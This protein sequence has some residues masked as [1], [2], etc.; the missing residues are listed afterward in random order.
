MKIVVLDGYC[1]N[2]GD[3]S[4]DDWKAL[5]DFELF[6]RTP[7]DKT[8]E[9]AR[10]AEIAITNKTVFDR[11]TIEAL[12]NLKYIG[13]LATGYNVID[14]EAAAE[15]GVPV[16]NVPAYS[17][18]SVAEHTIGL[19]L[20]LCRCAGLHSRLVREGEW[21]SSEDFS[22]WRAPQVE[23]SGKTMGIIGLGSIGRRVGEIALAMNMKTLG[24]KNKQ[25]NPLAGDFE[26]ASKERVFSEADVVSLHC[27]QLPETEGMVNAE[28]LSMM[29]SSAF[30]LNTSRGGLIV[31]EDLAKALNEERIAGAALDVMSIEPPPEGNPLFKAKNCLITPHIAWTTCEARTRLMKT[32]VDNL[33][34]FLNGNPVNVVNQ[35]KR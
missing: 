16:T 24:N 35:P 11:E 6:D 31:D 4:W 7:K 27:P 28:T 23:L 21:S 8:V 9:R 18:D 32:A 34:S 2:P 29:K 25:D 5:G 10:D 14:V 3:L 30:L 15:R 1:L 33:R 20:E 12:P 13:V 22:F 26:W 19:L 17:A